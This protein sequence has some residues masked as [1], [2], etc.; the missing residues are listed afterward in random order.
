MLATLD[1]F[2]GADPANL[3]TGIPML[4]AMSSAENGLNSNPAAP[5]CFWGS[6]TAFRAQIR[7]PQQENAS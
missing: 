6:A 1:Q 5:T 2:D 3:E 4:S 7:I